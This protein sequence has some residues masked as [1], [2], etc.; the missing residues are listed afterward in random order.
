[1]IPFT[2]LVPSSVLGVA[3]CNVLSFDFFTASFF[4]FCSL[5]LI[6]QIPDYG[7][8]LTFPGGDFVLPLFR[9]V[10]YLCIGPALPLKTDATLLLCVRS[11]LV[12]STSF[13]KEHF[14]NLSFSCAFSSHIR[15]PSFRAMHFQLCRISLWLFQR[16]NI[17]SSH[18]VPVSAFC[19]F[20]FLTPASWVLFLLSFAL[21]R[22]TSAKRIDLKIFR[23][24]ICSFLI[25]FKRSAG[26][27]YFSTCFSSD[28][29]LSF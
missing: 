26:Q 7:V 18:Q 15:F 29:S 21:S 5:N 2:L 3:F 9:G 19:V 4:G 13:L 12:K 28:S 24:S 1:M 16:I 6:S 25:R 11:A 20:R 10:A 8:P 22:H 23:T 17:F 27:T 14:N